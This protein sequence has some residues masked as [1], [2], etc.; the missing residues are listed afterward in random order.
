MA[1]FLNKAPLILASGSPRRQEMLAQVGL[2]FTV[3]VSEINEH[4]NANE[5]PEFFVKRLAK[6]KAMA[7][8]DQAK[9]WVL[10]A[11]TV[12]VI[13]GQILGKPASTAEAVGMLKRLAGNVHDVWT[14][15]CIINGQP[16]GLVCRAVRTKVHFIDWQSDIFTAYANSGDS[17]DKAGGYG[18]QGAGGVLVRE[19][20]GSYSN[21]VGLPM[22]EV[23]LEMVR[24]GVI[25]AK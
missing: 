24:L 20:S 5:E 1:T 14:G 17:L 2:D 12:V 25:Q 19:I 23:M 18:I 7:V 4:L 8:V 9:S 21:V 3:C 13:D 10:A 11:D 22:A 16:E 15:F 6:E